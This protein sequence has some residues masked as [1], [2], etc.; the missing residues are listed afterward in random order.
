MRWP[1]PQVLLAFGMLGAVLQPR[2]G[3]DPEEIQARG[4]DLLV[5]L[6][7]SWSMRARDLSPDRLGFAREELEALLAELGSDRI[8]LIIFAGEAQRL[9]PLT[10]D[11]QAFRELLAMASPERLRQ[12]GTDLAAALAQ[13]RELL[14]A[15]PGVQPT[16][17]L[18]S[19]GE[20]RAGRGLE[21]AR[22]CADAGVVVHAFGIGTADGGKI[23][24]ADE[25][26]NESYLTDTAGEEVLTRLMPN[27][28]RAIAETTGGGLIARAAVGEPT[29]PA[30]YREV[31]L[32]QAQRGA[33]LDADLP[34][35][36]RFQWPLGVALLGGLL[37]LAG[38][39]RRRRG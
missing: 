13:A 39:G 38:T 24:L 21:E 23:T 17:L 4:V 30:W 16:V 37:L 3:A 32:P 1:W 7:V 25:D 10:T 29:L 36:N 26:G 14:A 34:R 28:L 31:L 6:D 5:C 11:H 9:A 15:S 12:E 8:G 19:D 2:W 20:D 33:R 18:L 35:A 27:S 22:R